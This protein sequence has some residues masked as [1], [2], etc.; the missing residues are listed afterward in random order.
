[1]GLLE[2]VVKDYNR[3]CVVAR[4]IHIVI[5]KIRDSCDDTMDVHAN[6]CC[7]E[8]TIELQRQITVMI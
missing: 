8:C 7:Y 4:L 1:M 5:G 3:I 2:D 6:D